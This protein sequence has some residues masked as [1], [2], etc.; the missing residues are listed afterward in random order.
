M[1]LP[2]ALKRF[3]ASL[4]CESLA[5]PPPIFSRYITIP[6]IDSS[7]VRWSILSIHFFSWIFFMLSSNPKIEGKENENEKINENENKNLENDITIILKIKN[8]IK[9]NKF[10][11]D[12]LKMDYLFFKNKYSEFQNIKY[13]KTEINNFEIENNILIENKLNMETE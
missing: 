1:V 2:A 10:K 3:N 6:S 7:S 8:E 13:K 9:K 5:K 4:A 11:N 12:K